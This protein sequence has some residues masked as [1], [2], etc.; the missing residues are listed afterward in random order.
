MGLTRLPIWLGESHPCPYLTGPEARLGWIDPHTPMTPALYAALLQAGCRRSG[1]AVYRPYCASCHDCIPVR[2]PVIDFAPNRSQRRTW[3]RNADLHVS[4]HPAELRDEHYEL[5]RRYQ[6][7][8]H[9]G[10]AMAAA[11]RAEVMEFLGCS[12][13]EPWFVEF[14]RDTRLVAVAVMD[15][16]DDALSA[17]YTFY[18]PA[19]ART[20]PGVY[21]ILYLIR[22]ARRFGLRWCYLGYWIPG[23]RKMNYKQWFRPLEA[24]LGEQW[25]RF[26]HGRAIKFAPEDVL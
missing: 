14:R 11:S 22:L 20:G 1:D 16:L 3:S 24:R 12:W 4:L 5:Y 10:E 7:A 2:I 26:D 18:D 6:R 8:R 15:G 19:E 25:T 17:V 9:P 13:M 23:C 21:A